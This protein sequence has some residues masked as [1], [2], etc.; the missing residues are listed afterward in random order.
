MKEEMEKVMPE[1][2]IY[3]DQDHI[4][5]DGCGSGGSEDL[6]KESS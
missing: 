6:E 1:E 2:V 5:P 3:M 4:R